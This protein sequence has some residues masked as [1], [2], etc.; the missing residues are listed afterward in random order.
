MKFR[1]VDW[2]VWAR[3]GRLSEI[4]AIEMRK[5]MSLSR[6]KMYYI[7][8]DLSIMKMNNLTLVN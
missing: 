2:I 1:S 5:E 6:P 7:N 8:D 3:P 4:R